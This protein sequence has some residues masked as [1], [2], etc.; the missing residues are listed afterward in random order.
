MSRPAVAFRGVLLAVPALLQVAM[1]AEESVTASADSCFSVDLRGGDCRAVSPSAIGYSPKWGGAKDP[2]AYVVLQKVM[3]AG[4]ANAI[5][6]TLATF[7]S[8]E[9]SSFAYAVNDGDE[10][11]VRLLHRTYSASGVEIGEPLVRDVSFGYRSETSADFVADSRTNSL[12]SM[13]DVGDQVGLA[14]S[15][16]WS[17]N[18]AG[19][20][21][22]AVQF[23]GQ[24]GFPVATN[25]MF[26]ATADAEGTTAMRGVGRG[27]WRLLYLITDGSGNV[28]LEYLTD[29]FKMKSGF[30][31]SLR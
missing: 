23:S 25:S 15:T 7:A 16:A 6:N 3:C 5:T 13:V 27:W 30:I 21:I 28:L 20:S 4:T 12:Q 18:A 10:R 17:T 11:C 19:V 24:N 1:A 29:E 31:M 22:M 14:Y 26:S 2:G 9:E 8:E